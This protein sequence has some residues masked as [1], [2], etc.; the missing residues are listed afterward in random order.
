MTALLEKNCVN[1]RYQ[2][3]SHHFS[4]IGLMQGRKDGM[5]PSSFPLLFAADAATMSVIVYAPISATPHPAALRPPPAL[6]AQPPPADS[7]NL[8][9]DYLGRRGCRKRAP[10]SPS[11]R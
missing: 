10:P 1:F 2:A 3:M 8:S 5:I 7:R 4:I 6:C 9:R 11:R